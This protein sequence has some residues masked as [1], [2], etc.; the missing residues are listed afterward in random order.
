M[1]L[2]LRPSIASCFSAFA[3]DVTVTRP[4]PDDT[5]IAT[6]G[7]WVPPLMDDVPVGGEFQRREP[8]IVMA[9]TRAAVPTVPKKTL[10][11][12]PEFVGGPVLRWIVD[13]LE[14]TDV[15]HH[16]VLVVPDVAL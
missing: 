1:S 3:V 9:L 6:S 13:A 10:I 7:I 5:P 11:E 16:R 12:A 8:Q 4:A 2:D 14:R 15:D